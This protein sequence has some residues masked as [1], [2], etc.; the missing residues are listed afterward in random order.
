MIPRSFPKC[1]KTVAGLPEKEKENHTV[2]VTGNKLRYQKRACS[3]GKQNYL[4]SF[5]TVLEIINY[6]FEIFRRC[7]N[8]LFQTS[9]FLF[10]WR[11]I[12]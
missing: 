8:L 3:Y 1:Q 2:T 4:F 12:S 5:S 10:P 7:L 11:L 6:F 9:N